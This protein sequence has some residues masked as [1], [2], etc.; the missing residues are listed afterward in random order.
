MSIS[1]T[2]Q[3]NESASQK[4][5]HIQGLDTFVKENYMLSRERATYYGQITNDPNAK[6]TEEFVFKV[7]LQHNLGSFAN[8]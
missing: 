4:T 6:L 8:R 3:R 7:M 2:M 1:D 5:L